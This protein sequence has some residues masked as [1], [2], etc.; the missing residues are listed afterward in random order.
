MQFAR[1]RDLSLK[2]A[3]PSRDAGSRNSELNALQKA[4]ERHVSASCRTHS[5]LNFG[6]ILAVMPPPHAACGQR[7]GTTPSARWFAL[8]KFTGSLS[9][10][11]PRWQASADR[12]LPRSARFSNELA[13]LPVGE[14]T[15]R[16]RQSRFNHRAGSNVSWILFSSFP[17]SSSD[18]CTWMGSHAGILVKSR[19]YSRL[20]EI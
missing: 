1:V 8:A 19:V 2:Q 15:A 4:G 10:V 6:R 11:T 5:W 9:M 7:I 20:N 16:A 14:D 12:I 13:M 18:R 17:K 3:F